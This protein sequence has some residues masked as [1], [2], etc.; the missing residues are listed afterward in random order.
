MQAATRLSESP[1]RD[2]LEVDR[3]FAARTEI[4]ALL[5]RAP[6]HKLACESCSIVGT[7]PL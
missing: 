2:A 7:M 4:A 5:A 1:W 6:R 3:H